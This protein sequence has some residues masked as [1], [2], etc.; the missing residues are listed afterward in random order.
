MLA[1]YSAVQI[2]KRGVTVQLH[3][4]KPHLLPGRVTEYIFTAELAPLY[5]ASASNHK[6]V[7]TSWGDACDALLRAAA[8]ARGL[9]VDEYLANPHRHTVTDYDD[10][11]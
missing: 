10:D 5:F 8:R 1:T 2:T 11:D 7:E 3:T 6:S 9:T 4:G